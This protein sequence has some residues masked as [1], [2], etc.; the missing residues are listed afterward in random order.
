MST[1]KAEQLAI[2]ALREYLL[3]TL[4]AKVDTI[5]GERAA[6]L[7]AGRA[8]PYIIP[9]GRQLMVG[10]RG[11]EVAVDLTTGVRTGDELAADVIAAAVPTVTATSDSMG[12]FEVTST[13]APVEGVPSSVSIGADPNEAGDVNSL[14]GWPRGG[15]YVI[16]GALIA[17]HTDAVWDGDPHHYDLGRCMWILIGNRTVAPRPNIRTDIHDVALELTLLAAEPTN[18]FRAAPEFIEQTIRS[19]REVLHED[20]T[21]DGRVAITHL[22]NIQYT[23]DTYTLTNT[24]ASPLMTEA[25]MSLR[26]SVFERD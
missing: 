18:D 25:R 1:V 7:K 11:A 12:R 16:R 13:T 22:P 21:L 26:I 4:P 2:T 23:P 8:G 15:T 20:R 5:N 3:R 24:A 19:V 6:S 9:A 17:P 14:F 10:A